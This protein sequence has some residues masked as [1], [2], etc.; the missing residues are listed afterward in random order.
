MSKMT[1]RQRKLVK[2]KEL[3]R[4]AHSRITPIVSSLPPPAPSVPEI[5][6][7]EITPSPS[8]GVQLKETHDVVTSDDCGWESQEVLIMS[9]LGERPIDPAQ[10][11]D[12]DRAF[13]RRVRHLLTRSLLTEADVESLTYT[14]ALETFI[15]RKRSIW[16]QEAFDHLRFAESKRQLW[17]ELGYVTR[18]GRAVWDLFRARIRSEGAVRR[19]LEGAIRTSAPDKRLVA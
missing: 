19:I 9:P 14:V 5:L 8:S 13:D 17:D 11:L 10:S 3:R 7:Q 4:Q 1:R 15:R 18:F 16:P 6:P 12:N 2:E